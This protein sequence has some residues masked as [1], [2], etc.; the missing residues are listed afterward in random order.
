MTSTD[1]TEQAKQWVSA[2][3][4]R[5]IQIERDHAERWHELE[6]YK[7]RRQQPTAP[8]SPEW[9]TTNRLPVED[10]PNVV[11]LPRKMRQIGRYNSKGNTK[12]PTKSGVE[13][14]A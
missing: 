14:A 9:Y 4:I 10:P 6:P 11:F 7:P 5:A 8:A 2:A 13:N 1:R 12:R 3:L